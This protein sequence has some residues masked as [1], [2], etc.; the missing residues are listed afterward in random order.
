MII[1]ALVMYCTLQC[2]A[3]PSVSVLIFDSQTEC[4]SMRQSLEGIRG[5]TMGNDAPFHDRMVCV[6]ALTFTS[7]NSEKSHD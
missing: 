2:A 7:Q 4:E 3:L 1:Y 5:E 6:A